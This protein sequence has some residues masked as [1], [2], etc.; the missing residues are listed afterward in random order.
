MVDV[1]RRALLKYQGRREAGRGC[2]VGVWVGSGDAGWLVAKSDLPDTKN[3][4]SP[5]PRL[6]PLVHL[7]HQQQKPTWSA[8]DDEER[9]C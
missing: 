9:G 2:V 8:N 5:R 7:A 1:R 3:T 4:A 6:R